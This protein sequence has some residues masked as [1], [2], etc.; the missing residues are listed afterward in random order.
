MMC[1]CLVSPTFVLFSLNPRS[2]IR[3]KKSKPPSNPPCGPPPGRGLGALV[4]PLYLT[5]SWFENGM[6]GD[7]EY[8]VFLI[9]EE[10]G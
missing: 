4:S 6:C 2:L 5:I 8:Y 9:I 1:I 10:W 3:T 7:I